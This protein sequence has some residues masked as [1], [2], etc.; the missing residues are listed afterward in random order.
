[1]HEHTADNMACLCVWRCSSE[2]WRW[3]PCAFIGRSKGLLGV[4][5][6]HGVP[7]FWEKNSA[8]SCALG[9][10]A[11]QTCLAHASPQLSWLHFQ[12]S[13]HTALGLSLSLLWPNACPSST[14]AIHS[15]AVA[16]LINTGTSVDRDSFWDCVTEQTEPPVALCFR[17]AYSCL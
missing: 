3:G 2:I 14:T 8:H 10:N 11:K 6:G 1:M 17:L 15:Q 7:V 16:F 12:R 13:P 9:I 5:T 4:R